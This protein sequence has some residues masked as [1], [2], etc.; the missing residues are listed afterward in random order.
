MVGKIIQ[1]GWNTVIRLRRA[2]G[3][4][5]LVNLLIAAALSIPLFFSLHR[6]LDYS[7]LR[8]E[9]SSGFS[10]AWWSAFNFRAEGLAA[11][12]RPS[13]SGGFG[14]IFDNLELLVSG[15]WTAYGIAV[16]ILGIAYVLLAAF[17]NGGFVGLAVEERPFSTQRFF[18][19]SGLYFHH[20][21]ALA[22]TAL[23][24]F[25][26][27]YKGLYPLVFSLVEKLT[28][29]SLSQPWVWF[30]NLVAY[31]L[32]IKVIFI[33]TMI[34]DYA[35]VILITDKKESAW[36]SIGLATLFVFRHY[37]AWLINALLVGIGVLGTLTAALVLSAFR[38][39]AFWSLITL[40]A[41]Q[42]LFIVGLISL[43]L[44]F[45]ASQVEYYRRQK[46]AETLVRKKRL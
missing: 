21:A 20:M 42:Q 7:T 31:L 41:L 8:S 30:V 3:V 10:Y 12:L 13:L 19:Q 22:V 29:D 2:V 40:S 11:T 44:T 32:L 43:R 35:R 9:M 14:P 5:Y 6:N 27:I 18:S 34:L 25:L 26:G 15:N 17:F 28:A 33:V 37:R 24:L 39:T 16:F 1:S 23:L 36:I 46:E 4:I 45:Y 38:S